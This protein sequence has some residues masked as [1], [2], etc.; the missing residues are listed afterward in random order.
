MWMECSCIFESWN[1]YLTNSLIHMFETRL[2]S[3]TNKSF[4]SLL[5]ISPCVCYRHP[6][7]FV[8]LDT[9]LILWP[10]AV[11][12]LT[13]VWFCDPQQYGDWHTFD[14]VTHSS[15]GTDTFDYVIHSSKETDTILILW[16]TAVWGT[17]TLLIL[18]PTAVW[19][20]DTCLWP[21]AVWGLTHIWLCD[22]QQYGDW[23]TFG[24][25]AHS[26]MGTHTRWRQHYRHD[27]RL[28]HAHFKPLFW[29][30][31]S[32]LSLNVKALWLL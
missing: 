1:Y 8:D 30:S 4:V 16:P 22:P 12:G 28:F 10:T 13:H 23:H 3:R 11:W 14:S 17:D 5:R 6:Q 15:M 19:G 24:S 21:T 2:V 27:P 25:V 31:I 9:F 29:T 32:K 7:Q 18:W 20:T 26:S